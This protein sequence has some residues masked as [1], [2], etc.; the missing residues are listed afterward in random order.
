[1]RLNKLLIFVL[2][3]FLFSCSSK[4]TQ[5]GEMDFGE[6]QPNK[7]IEKTITVDFNSAAKADNNAFLEFEFVDKDGNPIN[8]V[9]FKIG[10]KTVNNKFKVMPS[11][12]DPNGKIR[13]GIQFKSNA[14]EKEYNGYLRLI[15]S[16]DALKMN[17]SLGDTSNIINYTDN[18]SKF[19]CTYKVPMEAW[20]FWS[21]I[22][23]ILLIVFGFLYLILTRDNMIFGKKTFIHGS[24][25]FPNG[26]L[27]SVR[28]DKLA[29]FDV[30]KVFGIDSG[31][32]IEPYDKKVINKVTRM[33][34]LKN[35]SNFDIKIMYDNIEQSI[36]ASEDL[37]NFDEIKIIVND[38]IYQ[39]NYINSKIVRTSF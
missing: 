11:D 12:V 14:S 8:N 19:H 18:V 35:N 31:I 30:S 3:L 16:S 34:R 33:A 28:L 7:V 29:I 20:K 23:S 17:I 36:G 21:I 5:I 32:Y 24:I 25:G 6:V 1:M 22:F 15:N 38:K 37:Y 4:K 27:S 2:S 9:I 26:E 10:N 13:V 39:F